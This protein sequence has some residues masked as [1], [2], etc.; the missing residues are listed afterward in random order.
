MLRPYEHTIITLLLLL[1]DLGSTY[2][3]YHHRHRHRHHHDVSTKPRPFWTR[4]LRL[5]AKRSDDANEME[6][7]VVLANQ[8]R[9][10][11]ALVIPKGV[12]NMT[13][14]G[15]GF[16]VQ[17]GG[18]DPNNHNSSNNNNNSSSS[19]SSSTYIVT[20]AH[21]AL[22]GHDVEVVL[23]GDNQKLAQTATVLARNMTLDLALLRIETTGRPSTTTATTTTT[24]SAL[25]ISEDF[26][27][28]GTTT[29]AFGYP[30]TNLQQG[31]AMTSGIVCGISNGLGMPD[32]VVTD[33]STRMTPFN[34]STTTTTYVVTDAGMSSGMSGGPL[35]DR[36][37]TVLGV[38]SLIRPDL[39]SLGNYAV[40]SK[41]LQ[42]FLK[43][44]WSRESG[45]N[46][47]S[48]D[49]ATYRIVLFNDPMNKKERV[50]SVL[51]SIASLDNEEAN[52]IMMKAHRT[53]QSTVQDGLEQELAETMCAMLRKEDVL[54]EVERT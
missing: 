4:G 31:P 43:A 10:K 32:V 14:R 42:A 52:N 39:R 22:P 7:T 47:G 8:I 27:P 29:F 24:N 25:T 1:I 26:P 30:A 12:R 37:G 19:S 3:S 16:V 41:E 36:T 35:V 11:V 17:V 9:P 51:Q 34:N 28:V 33:D 48:K 44:A 50:A 18:G 6:P 45:T 40:S 23:G 21:V 54:V 38:I 2:V 5:W 15:S 53:G 49:M 46:N 20:A 13:A